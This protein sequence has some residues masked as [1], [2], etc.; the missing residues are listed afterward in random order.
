MLTL[1]DGAAKRSENLCA[2]ILMH[3]SQDRDFTRNKI[4]F[5]RDSLRNAFTL[6]ASKD[7]NYCMKFY[8]R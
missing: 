6:A 5:H 2:L 4:S 7:N 8:E 3:R 1:K